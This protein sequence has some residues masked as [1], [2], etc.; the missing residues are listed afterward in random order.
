MI[1]Q[2]VRLA[3]IERVSCWLLARS[4][5]ISSSTLTDPV[6]RQVTKF[7]EL[8]LQLG[9]RLFEIE[10]ADGHDQALTQY[11]LLPA[12]VRFNASPR[13]LEENQADTTELALPSGP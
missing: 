6:G 12:R 1:C 8:G 2:G 4:L 10:E 5:P 3:K 11:L 13:N 7:L 9:D